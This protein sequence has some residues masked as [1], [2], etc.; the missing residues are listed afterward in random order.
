MLPP[1]AINYVTDTMAIVSFKSDLHPYECG[2]D[3]EHCRREAST[4]HSPATCVFCWDD[5]VRWC[6]AV[7]GIYRVL[8]EP[9][10]LLTA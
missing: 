3:C 5:L 1:H 2:Q 9:Q 7:E 10:R 4:E 8:F 6:D